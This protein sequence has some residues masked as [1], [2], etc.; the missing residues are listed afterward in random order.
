MAT[1]TGKNL[2]S[3]EEIRKLVVARLKV[4]SSDI[5]ISVGSEGSFSRDELV[6]KVQEGDR[7]G[8]KLAEIQMGWLQSL[9]EGVV[10]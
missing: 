2:L 6:K 4:L 1:D 9:K 8:E 10:K 5:L 3:D 7:V